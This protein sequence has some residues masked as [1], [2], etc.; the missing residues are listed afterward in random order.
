MLEPLAFQYSF[1]RL[2]HAQVKGR[3]SEAECMEGW[4]GE[5]E[6]KG[7]R[8][9]SRGN[10]PVPTSA[11]GSAYLFELC[12]RVDV[13]IADFTV[14]RLVLQACVSPVNRAL[15]FHTYPREG[16]DRPA[17]VPSF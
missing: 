12:L 10:P 11:V 3:E 5:G 9:G 14:K 6:Q 1:K 16:F 15:A 4:E 13:H 2:T 7:G 8:A 17:S